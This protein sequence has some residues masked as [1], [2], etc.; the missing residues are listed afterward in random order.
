MRRS[1]DGL[2]LADNPRTPT[3]ERSLDHARDLD[4]VRVRE[5]S[6]GQRVFGRTPDRRRRDNV[7]VH[8]AGSIRG[9]DDEIDVVVEALGGSSLELGDVR[10][11]IDRL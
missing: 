1:P 4:R 6:F 7:R 9:D 8:V 5:A 3:R 2:A 11:V 10:G